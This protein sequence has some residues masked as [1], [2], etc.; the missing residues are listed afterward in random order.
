MT[1]AIYNISIIIELHETQNSTM[2]R[3]RAV[4]T[5]AITVAVTHFTQC[6]SCT[7]TVMP[8]VYNNGVH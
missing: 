1:E 4:S 3:V 2:I 6:Q 5:V 7:Y 8:T